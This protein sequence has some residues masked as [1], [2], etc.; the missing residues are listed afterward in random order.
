MQNIDDYIKKSISYSVE[1][2]GGYPGDALKIYK[3]LIQRKGF[4]K[5]IRMR[6]VN[7]S[8]P[9]RVNPVKNPARL[10]LTENEKKIFDIFFEETNVSFEEIVSLSRRREIVDVRK[11]IMVVFCV[12]LD[13]TYKRTGDLIGH[14][15]HSTVIHAIN[16]HD[17]LLHC[18]VKY[19]LKFKKVLDRVKLE[20]SEFFN[21]K[22][23][24]IS[25]L[26]KEFDQVKWE[27][28]A[29]NWARERRNKKELE[30][31]R[32]LLEKNEL[33]KSN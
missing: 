12:Y 9:K 20:L 15:D 27:R 24:T 6:P 25:D 16:T 23:V 22:S 3:S 31:L 17:G 14:R 10:N 26:K 19:S 11:M 18:D 21:Q 7:P 29:N 28:F 13:Y 32:E 1:K 2:M 4:E 5:N 33:A 8:K 30:E